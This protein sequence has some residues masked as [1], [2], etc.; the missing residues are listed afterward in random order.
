MYCHKLVMKINL[1]VAKLLHFSL[2]CDSYYCKCTDTERKTMVS[3]LTIVLRSRFSAH[4][5]CKYTFFHFS[6]LYIK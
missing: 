4:Y 3:T 1:K 6:Q 5:Y 2:L